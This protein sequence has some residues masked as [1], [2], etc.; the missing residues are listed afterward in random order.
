M[1]RRPRVTR[2]HWKDSALPCL[3]PGSWVRG[4]PFMK[5]PGA[6]AKKPSPAEGNQALFPLP[7]APCCSQGVWVPRCC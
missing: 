4:C 6:S 7:G 3:P 5:A 1:P 2:G